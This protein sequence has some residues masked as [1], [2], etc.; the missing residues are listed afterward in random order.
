[1][2]NCCASIFAFPVYHHQGIEELVDN[3]PG[4]FSEDLVDATSFHLRHVRHFPFW[5]ILPATEGAPDV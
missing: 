3:F 2:C 5:A 4:L 1:M